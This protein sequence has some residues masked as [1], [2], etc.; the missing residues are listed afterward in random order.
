MSKQKRSA[1][2]HHTLLPASNARGEIQVP[3]VPTHNVISWTFGRGT[4]IWSIWPAFLLHTAFAAVITVISLKTRY[5]LGVPQ[6]LITVLGV[7]IGFVISYRAASGYDR[8]WMGRVIWSD[9]AK[10]S[11]TMGRLIWFHVPLK[12]SPN[13][14]PKEEREIGRLMREKRLALDLIEG[15]VVATK[16]HLRGEMG[17]YHEDL[18]HLLRPLHNHPAG[19]YAAPRP[20]T[21]ELEDIDFPIDESLV[22]TSV[23]ASPPPRTFLSIHDPFVPPINDYGTF[24]PDSASP[25]SRRRGRV[26]RRASSSSCGSSGNGQSHP[27][28]LPSQGKKHSSHIITELIP[29]ASI[30]PGAQ[31]C[32]GRRKGRNTPKVAGG[33]QNIPIEIVRCLSEWLSVLDERATVSGNPLGGMYGCL[34][35]FEDSLSA[36]ERILTTPLPFIY[37]AHI[38]HAVWMY[39]FLLPFQLV[40][41]FGWYTIPGVG[42]AAFFYIGFLAAGEEIEQPFGYDDNDLDLDLFCR[43]IIH[44]DIESLKRTPC[45]NVRLPAKHLSTPVGGIASTAEVGKN[46]GQSLVEVFGAL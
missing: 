28:L 19:K 35:S 1:T 26:A 36:L 11:R 12:S 45:P 27:P 3:L 10:T 8:Y 25:T 23:V 21:H 40:G 14:E 13:E 32:A 43:E 17:Y 44:A 33:G 30:L 22:G 42:I 38:R 4:V 7:V 41:Q 39:L 46:K 31:R 15:F 16:H 34:T 20:E 6:V 9:L 29:F 37:S 18:Y 5:Y 24:D 2:G